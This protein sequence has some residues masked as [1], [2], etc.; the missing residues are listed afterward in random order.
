MGKDTFKTKVVF[1]KV[2]E[3]DVLALF[4]EQSYCINYKT[5]CYQHIGQH[6]E[7]DYQHCIAI[8]KLAT[9]GEYKDLKA[10]L[11]SLGYAL[12]VKQ[13]AKIYYN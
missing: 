5:E 7:A 4:P 12:E 10:E 1:R 6:G 3:G 11:E 8:T 13:R 9:P 2:K